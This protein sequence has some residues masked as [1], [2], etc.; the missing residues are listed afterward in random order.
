MEKNIALGKRRAPRKHKLARNVNDS[1]QFPL[2]ASA[3]IASDADDNKATIRLINDKM[4][5]YLE[6]DARK[7]RTGDLPIEGVLEKL[8]ASRMCCH[9]CAKTVRVHYSEARDPLQWTLDRIDNTIG[10]TIGN[11]V[12]S[13]LGCN[14]K[15]RTTEQ[16]KFEFTQN[17]SLE[18]VDGPVKAYVDGSCAG[19]NRVREN[20][21]RAGWGAVILDRNTTHNL[22]GPVIL[23]SKDKA[24]LGAEVGSNNTG[25]LSA[26][27]EALIYIEQTAPQDAVLLYDSEYAYNMITGQKRAHAN[28]SLVS[29]GKQLLADTQKK[30]TV[31]FQH[32][33]AHSGDQ[34]NDMADALA[35][36]GATGDRGGWGERWA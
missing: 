29:T 7:G 1:D 5:S 17:L 3:Y 20:V 32:V 22:F 34:H 9:Y 2:I 18:K 14:L 21:C 27:C 8:L 12:V 4:R 35:K 10:H 6:Q 16:A 28:K 31:T 36:R 26:M 15:R 24:F 25:E 19:N 11:V 30:T 13:C 23:D 33:K